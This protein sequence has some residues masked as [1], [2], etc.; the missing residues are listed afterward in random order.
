MPLFLVS[1]S[2]ERTQLIA[3]LRRTSGDMS[4]VGAAPLDFQ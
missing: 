3:T 2:D 4:V 1:A